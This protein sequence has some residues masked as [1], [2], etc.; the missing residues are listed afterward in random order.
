MRDHRNPAALP[1]QTG[2]GQPVS[3]GWFENFLEELAGEFRGATRFVRAPGEG[4]WRSGG[5][6]ERDNIAVVE[7]MAEPLVPEYWQRL[8]ERLERD[9]S[10]EA[11]VIRAQETIQ[12]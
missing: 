5:E 8:R 12:L 11:I 1:K 10:Q 3:Q 2:N 6:T 7:V 9:L 4:L